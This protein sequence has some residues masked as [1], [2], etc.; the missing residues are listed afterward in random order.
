M[1]THEEDELLCRVEGEAPTGQL[2]RS[3]TSR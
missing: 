2:M 1:L 3:V